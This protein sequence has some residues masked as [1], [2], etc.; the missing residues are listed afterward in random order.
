MKTDVDGSLLERVREIGPVLRAN[1]AEGERLRRLPQGSFDALTASG[2]L[3]ML[4]PRSM[5]G[6]ELDPVSYAS[7]IEETV[8]FDPAAAWT[9]TN[10]LLWAFFCSRLPGQ[11]ALELLGEDP[12]AMFAASITPPMKAEPVEGGFKITGDGRFVSNCHHARWIAATCLIAEDSTS[13]PSPDQTS[14]GRMIWAYISQKDCKILDTW[15]VLGMRAT[16]SDDIRVDG[17]F[18]PA[19][20]AFPFTPE[21]ELGP[22]FQGPLYR[23]SFIGIVTAALTPVMLGIARVAIDEAAS[24]A[25]E[26]T[27]TGNSSALWMTP[28]VQSQIG[29]VEAA[30]RAARALLYQTLDDVWQW[31]LSGQDV[32]TAQRADLLLAATNASESSVRVVE[33]MHT[34]AGTTGIYSGNPIERCFRDIQVARQHRFYT[35]G[36]YETFG[37]MYF[38]LEP[39]YGMVML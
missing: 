25:R 33:R 22:R 15:D 17:A 12:R 32:T 8:R 19:Y 34:L 38:G 37:R 26:K 14:R 30:L 28:S 20:R 27:A 31:V 3:T 24:L 16:G 36:R 11:G 2:L 21:F 35:E 1:V 4:T 7:V 29:Q 10:P 13:G 18:V 39:D 6:L 9:L 23:F 5:G